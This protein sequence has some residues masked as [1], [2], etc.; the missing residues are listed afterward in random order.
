VK[1]PWPSLKFSSI[2]HATINFYLDFSSTFFS[3]RMT[4]FKIDLFKISA[5]TLTNEHKTLSFFFLNSQ[6]LEICCSKSISIP[7][8]LSLFFMTFL[9][10]LSMI[11]FKDKI[12]FS[13]LKNCRTNAKNGI[14]FKKKSCFLRSFV[15]IGAHWT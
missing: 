6:I 13:G 8:F 3:S 7:N 9:L 1:N 11:R 2:S 12:M 5:Q 15:N 4:W 10:L 14:F